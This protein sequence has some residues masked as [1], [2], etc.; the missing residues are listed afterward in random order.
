MTNHNN[1]DKD[2]EDVYRC[3]RCGQLYPE[4]T[5]SRRPV[6]EIDHYEAGEPF[7]RYDQAVLELLQV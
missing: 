7:C 6:M 3:T 1:S 2:Q 4:S 5:V